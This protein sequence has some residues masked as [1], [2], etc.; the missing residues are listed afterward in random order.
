[1]MRIVSTDSIILGV[2][3][4]TELC[5]DDDGYA[6]KAKEKPGFGCERL[7]DGKD[8]SMAQEHTSGGGD[9]V[10]LVVDQ[11][12]CSQTDG[13]QLRQVVVS[14][15]LDSSSSYRC[16]G[17]SSALAELRQSQERCTARY[18]AAMEQ[19]MRIERLVST[20]QNI[21]WMRNQEDSWRIGDGSVA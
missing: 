6:G 21:V 3:T 12:G 17:C 14:S 18:T 13:E 20:L 4:S 10:G 15:R 16:R 8:V 5:S 1:M 11:T 2:M 19:K 7:H 9:S